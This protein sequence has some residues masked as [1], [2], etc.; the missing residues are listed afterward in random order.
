MNS[1]FV[2]H[3]TANAV[4]IWFVTAATW[5]EIRDRLD[6]RSRAFA[7]AAGFEPKAGRHLLLPAKAGSSACCSGSRQPDEKSK[8][9]FLPGRLR[10]CC[11]PAPTG[12][13]TRRTTRGSRR[14][15]LRSAPIASPA[16]ARRTR[17]KM[18]LELPHG[19]DGADL[20]RIV[21]AVDARA[22]PHQHAGERHGAGRARG[23]GAALAARHGAEIRAI[24]G[25]DLLAQ[26]F[27][28]IHAVGRAARRRAAADRPHAGATPITRRSRWSARACASTPAGST[29]SPTAAC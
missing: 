8:D 7:D 10:R 20:S 26:N 22:R 23:G 27:P 13:P 2:A 9:P 18:R 24:V 21:E 1:I 25:D 14:S 6:G 19:V 4:P 17:P 3:G 15:P 29:S 11:R 12:S 5:T 28:L 16:I